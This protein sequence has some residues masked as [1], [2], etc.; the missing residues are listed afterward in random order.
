M[1]KA[2]IVILSFVILVPVGFFLT[3]W[4]LAKNFHFADEAQMKA[5]YQKCMAVPRGVTL[6]ELKGVL[7]EPNAYKNPDPSYFDW[8]SSNYSLLYSSYIS[9]KVDDQGIVTDL[10]CGEDAYPWDKGRK[11]GQPW[12]PKK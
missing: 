2:I 11:S 9:A 7:G 3:V 6:Q 1:K 5:M 12:P 4:V 10:S 8:G